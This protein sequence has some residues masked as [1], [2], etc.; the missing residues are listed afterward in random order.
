MDI[1]KSLK[2]FGYVDAILYK[3]VLFPT[4][5]FF[6][7]GI[8]LVEEIYY[9]AIS[10]PLYKTKGILQLTKNEYDKILSSSYEKKFDLIVEQ[11]PK[12]ITIRRQYGMR[13]VLK[14]EFDP[15][16]YILRVGF[17]DFPSCPYANSFKML[18]YDTKEKV[19]V[20]LA[21]TILKDPRLVKIDYKE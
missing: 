6:V 17:D 18:G 11:N 4:E 21:S 2:K 8:Y 16:R 7:D 20:R 13:K 12:E 9:C 5:H 3:E 14:S 15:K 1:K 19:Y 10:A